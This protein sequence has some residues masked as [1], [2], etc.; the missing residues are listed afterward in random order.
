[1]HFTANTRFPTCSWRICWRAVSVTKRI[2]SGARHRGPSRADSPGETHSIK[3]GKIN[4]DVQTSHSERV[5]AIISAVLI[6]AGTALTM[7]G[8]HAGGRKI[9]DRWRAASSGKK[10][11]HP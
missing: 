3:A 2:W 11:G 10:K 5:S 1:M 9:E 6:A 4:I 8:A 7:A